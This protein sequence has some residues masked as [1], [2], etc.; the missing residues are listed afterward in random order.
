MFLKSPALYVSAAVIDLS[1]KTVHQMRESEI[2]NGFSL[3]A[4]MYLIKDRTIQGE[5]QWSR[6]VLY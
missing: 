5:L 6:V 2:E 1:G 3:Q 4:G